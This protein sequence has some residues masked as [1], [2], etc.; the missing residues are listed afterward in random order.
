MSY[1]VVVAITTGRP[2]ARC[3]SNSAAAQ[4]LNHLQQPLG[5]DSRGGLHSLLRLAFC[6]GD[7]LAGQRHRRQG[8][9]D[10]VEQPEQQRLAGDASD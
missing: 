2:A 9:A 3:S 8:F 10:G 7:G 5:S 1:G 6:Q 4:R